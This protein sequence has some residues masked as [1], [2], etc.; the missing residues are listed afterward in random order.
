MVNK[1][2]QVETIKL[3]EE[4]NW[5]II[6]HKEYQVTTQGKTKLEALL[7]LADALHYYVDDDEDLM[8]LSEDIFLN[9]EE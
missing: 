4:D 5:W 6:T 1:P 2:T 3:W 7:M 8:E 9:P